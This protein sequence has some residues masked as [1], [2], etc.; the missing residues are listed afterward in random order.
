LEI[1]AER[2]LLQLVEIL[3]ARGEELLRLLE[4]N[5]GFDSDAPHIPVSRLDVEVLAPPASGDYLPRIAGRASLVNDDRGRCA[6]LRGDLVLVG[7]APVV[8]HRLA[9]EHLLVE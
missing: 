6:L 9:L 3:S 1:L 8:G 7:P 5:P 4:L 2:R